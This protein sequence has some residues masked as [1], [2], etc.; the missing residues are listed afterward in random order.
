LSIPPLPKGL[1]D[2]PRTRAAN[3]L[4]SL[5]IHLLRRARRA[6]KETGLGPERLS[7]LSVLAFAG[8]LTVGALAEIE[9]VS[10]PA[11]SRI[12]SA[13]E[14]EGLAEKQRSAADGREVRVVAT[15]SGRRLVEAGRRRRLE[16]I[17]EELGDLPARDIAL[18]AEIARI[19]A[20]L[21]RAAVNSR[22]S[23]SKKSCLK[24]ALG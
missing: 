8:P 6:D 19:L 23:A 13:L 17:A 4:H 22:R 5:S 21:D 3:A 7:L 1:V 11:I 10:P 12:V 15:A 16:L 9:G 18:L 14:G 2:A 20:R 24:S